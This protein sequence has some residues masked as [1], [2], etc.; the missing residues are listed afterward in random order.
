MKKAGIFISCLV[1]IA[2]SIYFYNYWANHQES[3][4]EKTI[5]EAIDIKDGN[6]IALVFSS[7]DK[8]SWQVQDQEIIN[9][10]LK[11]LG[12]Q[13]VKKMKVKG[14]NWKKEHISILVMTEDESNSITVEEAVVRVNK[15]DFNKGY[16]EVLNSPI[17]IEKFKK[18][19]SN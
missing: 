6:I 5:M 3:Y 2:N 14:Y 4:E 1:I 9:E 7:S 8:S 15:G 17:G 16:Y 12:V 10:F 18:F 11:F 13:K 19:K